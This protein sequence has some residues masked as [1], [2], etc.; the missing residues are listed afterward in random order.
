MIS[1]SRGAAAPSRHR[2]DSCPSDEVGGGFFFDFEAIWTESSDHD[3]P[4]RLEPVLTKFARDHPDVA[5]G[6]V[7]ATKRMNER[8]ADAHGADSYPTLRFRRSGSTEFVDYDGARDEEGF[9]LLAARLQKP[10]V[11]RLK[12]YDAKALEQLTSHKPR[13]AFL[14][15][16]PFDENLKEFESV[17]NDLA[18]VAS[19]ALVDDHK[20]TGLY[21]GKVGCVSVNA[22]AHRFPGGDLRVSSSVFAR[23]RSHRRDG[24]ETC[25]RPRGRAA[26]APP[27]RDPHR[28]T[29]SRSTTRS[30]SPSSAR[31]TSGGLG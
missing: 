14:L 4:R 9:S 7:D 27:T 25:S 23:L 20:N 30:S 16:A 2:R 10:A 24:V 19:F 28:R 11:A 15:T 3:A 17:A 8:L 31:T 5:V 1:A 29:G 18:H 26:A 6:K 21:P 12:K 22:S 13:V